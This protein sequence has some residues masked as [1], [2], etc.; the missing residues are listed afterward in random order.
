MKNTELFTEQFQNIEIYMEQFHVSIPILFHN[1]WILHEGISFLYTG[2]QAGAE[3]GQAQLRLSQ[4][5]I[6]WQ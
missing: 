2:K 6:S 5:L 1:N 3:L 4:L